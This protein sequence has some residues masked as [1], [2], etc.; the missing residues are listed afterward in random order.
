MARQEQLKSRDKAARRLS[1]LHER[2]EEQEEDD[3]RKKVAATRK[4]SC[5]KYGL[6][7]H[8]IEEGET[9]MKTLV[10]PDL[11]LDH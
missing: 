4:R 6:R 1:K 2:E 10:S 8:G 3:D 11:C 9:I 7:G 5:G